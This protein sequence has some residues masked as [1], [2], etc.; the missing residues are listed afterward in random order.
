[1]KKVLYFDVEYA[2]SKNQSIC[3]MGLLSEYFPSGEPIF[4]ER[5]I[6]INPED[7]FDDNCIRIHGITN[8]KVKNEPNFPTIWREVEP[9]FAN[10]I[11]I[12]HNVAV[13]DI[14]SLLKSCNRY[15]IDLPEI[16]YICTLDL[17]KKYIPRYKIKDY[18]L[19]TLCKY[20]DIDTDNCHNAFDDACACVDLFKTMVEN[21][22]IKIEKHTQTFLPHAT[23]EHAQYLSSPMIRKSIIDFYGTVRGIA[24]DRIIIPEEIAYIHQWREGNLKYTNQKEIADIIKTIDKILEDGF[25]N[26]EEMRELITTVE[27]YFNLITASPITLATQVLNGLLKGISIDKKISTIEGINLREW[28]YKNNYLKGYYPFDQIM[29]V[30]D[31]ILED[32]IITKEE[33]DSMIDVIKSLLEPVQE[34]QE[35]LNSVNGKHVCL[36]GIFSHGQKADVEKFIIQDGGFIDS[37]LKKTTDILIIGDNECQAYAFGSYGT[38]VQKAIE[39]SNKGYDIKIIK[40]SDYFSNNHFTSS[41]PCQFNINTTD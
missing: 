12:G 17:A 26:Y 35:R 34:L 25:I 37:S 8:G 3:Q 1:M 16:H 18:S 30:L 22:D 27:E 31:C 40:E 15:K 21:Y 10:S 19:S 24:L 2:N 5:D 29:S 38:K 28:M 4:P 33:S 39:Y 32:N 9:Y 6:Y 11:I 14:S 13:A 36:S 23:K 7:G 20:F 41:S